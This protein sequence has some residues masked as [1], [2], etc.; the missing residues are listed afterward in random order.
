MATVGPDVSVRETTNLIA[1][2]KVEGTPVRRSNGDKIGTIERVMIDKIS[3]KVAY[4]VL[5]FGGFLGIGDDYRA[6][7]WSVLDYNTDL[8]AYELNLSDDQLRGAPTT[9]RSF[10]DRGTTDRAW[11]QRLHDYYRAAPYW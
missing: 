10:Y 3:G 1:S 4:A 8:E 2:D 9:D 11:E 5:T 6:L 7:P